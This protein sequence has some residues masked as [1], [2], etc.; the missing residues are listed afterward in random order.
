VSEPSDFAPTWSPD[1]QWIMFTRNGTLHRM[2]PD[3]TMLT[4]IA[5]SPAP[6][7]HPA[8]SPDGLTLAYTGLSDDS[9]DGTGGN[10]DIYVMN[11]ATGDT[12]LT[13]SPDQEDTPRWSPDGS[14]IAYHRVVGTRIQLFRMQ[15][16]GSGAVNLT[17]RPVS[18]GQPS[19]GPV[20]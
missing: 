5:C 3:G 7:N 2:H 16:D 20:P 17:N 9:G 8:W 11:L 13:T 14:A 6:C 1:G 4:A 12:Q 15:A 10:Y 18:E 19:W